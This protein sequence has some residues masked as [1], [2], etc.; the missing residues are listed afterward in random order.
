MTFVVKDA[1][2]TSS[3]D[4][5]S[6]IRRQLAAKRCW[7]YLKTEWPVREDMTHR[8]T[9]GATSGGKPVAAKMIVKSSCGMIKA[10]S[11]KL[12]SNH[13]LHYRPLL[14]KRIQRECNAL[15]VNGNA[16]VHP[17]LL[18]CIFR[19]CSNDMRDHPDVKKVLVHKAR[20]NKRR[21]TAEAQQ[22]F[23]D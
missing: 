9:Y 13:G 4:A 5:S 17:H 11:T 10:Q 1:A 22:N 14:R 6:C 16:K 23:L 21:N 3:T 15:S 18:V 7:G 19:W 2:T 20:M 12:F 8:A